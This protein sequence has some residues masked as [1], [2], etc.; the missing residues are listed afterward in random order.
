LRRA[1][2]AHFARVRT[3]AAVS[4]LLFGLVIGGIALIG[5]VYQL[6][7]DPW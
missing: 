4:L 1:A 5:Q 2:A 7:S 3:I 6:Q